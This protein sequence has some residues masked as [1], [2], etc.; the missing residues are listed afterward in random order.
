LFLYQATGI[1]IRIAV[2]LGL[3][4]LLLFFLFTYP[5]FLIGG[6]LCV[7]LLARYARALRA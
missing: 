3:F 4:A 2:C 7:M 5:A 1:A 6:F